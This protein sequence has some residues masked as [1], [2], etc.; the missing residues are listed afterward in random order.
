MYTLVKEIH[1][2]TTVEHC[3]YCHFFNL[4]EKNLVIASFNQLKVYRLIG[5]DTNENGSTLDTNQSTNINGNGL[6]TTSSTSISTTLN[7]SNEPTITGI[8]SGDKTNNSNINGGDN[9]N[10][11]VKLECL[12]TIPL[13]SEVCCLKSIKLIGSKRDSLLIAFADAK[14]ALVEYDPADHDLKTLSLHY[15][16]DEDIKGGRTQYPRA[17]VI[18][19]DPEGRCAAMLIYGRTIVII[20]FRK[21][22]G[23]IEE[24]E[25]TTVPG[26]GK[27]NS[28]NNIPG[29]GTSS[30]QQ[31]QVTPNKSF[32]LGKSRTSSSSLDGGDN[33]NQA[34]YPVMASYKLNLNDKQYAEEKIHNITD[35]QFL[36]GYYEPTLFIL[37]EPVRTWAGRVAVRRD[38]CSMVTLSLNVHQRVH[39]VIWSTSHLPFD[40]FAALPVPKPVGGVIIFAVNSLIYLNQSVPPYA[41]SLN[42]FADSTTAFTKTVQ[43]G[44]KL[45]LDC[46]K[47]T[48]VSNDKLV[49]SLKGGELYVVTLFSDGMRSIRA[50]HFDKSASSVISSCMTIC[51]EGYLFLGSRLGNSLLLKYTEKIVESRP[52]TAKNIPN[53]SANEDDPMMCASS[54]VPEVLGEEVDPANEPTLSQPINNNNNNS[55]TTTNINESN[56]ADFLMDFMDEEDDKSIVTSTC[57]PANQLTQESDNMDSED[58]KPS[59][60]LLD[61]SSSSSSPLED[62]IEMVKVKEEKIDSEL[63]ATNV[64]IINDSV[65]VS[66][67]NPEIKDEST[68][69]EDHPTNGI[70]DFD[71][72][73]NDQSNDSNDSPNS[74]DSHRRSPVNQ[75][76]NESTVDSL[77]N[78]NL[79]NSNLDN[80]T[81]DNSNLYGPSESQSNY[82]N[83]NDHQM[84][85]LDESEHPIN[86]FDETVNDK[87]DDIGDWAAGD[88]ALMK[89]PD[90]LEVYGPEDDDE[91]QLTTSFSFELCDSLINIGP[92]GRTCMGEPAFL[93]EEFSQNSADP[94][95]ELVTTSG[96]GKNGAL[97]VLQRTIRPQL[98]TT[99]GLPKCIDMW[100]VHSPSLGGTVND[101]YNGYQ[102]GDEKT[103]SNFHSFLILTRPDTTM[104]LKTGADINELDHSDVS[105]QTPTI[106]AGNLANGKYILQVSPMAVRLLEGT[107]QI[108]HLPLNLGS[109]IVFCS[110]VDPYAIILTQHGAMALLTLRIDP[111]TSNCRLAAS[112]VSLTPNKAKVS[113]LCIYKDVSGKFTTHSSDTSTNENQSHDNS[114]KSADG[115]E[116]GFGS[117]ESSQVPLIA[118]TIDDEDELLYGTSSIEMITN[119]PD[120][121]PSGT[122]SVT[123]EPSI[124]SQQNTE[125]LISPKVI[126]KQPEYEPTYWLFTIR[127]NGVLEI[128]RIPDATS[129]FYVKTFPMG[130]K[131]LSDMIPGDEVNRSDSGLLPVA[132]E[133]LVT[134]MGVSC[135]RPIMFARF[136]YEI[137]IYEMFPYHDAQTPG[138]LQ[139]RWRRK[140]RT[141]IV[142]EPRLI[143]T[144]VTPP[145]NTRGNVNQSSS[146]QSTTAQNSNDSPSS[147]N[148]LNFEKMHQKWFRPFND[149]SGY[150]G[151]FICGPFPHWCFMTSRGEL[152]I[153]EMNIDGPV[154]S[155]APFHNVNCPKGFLYINAKSELR[156]AVLPTHVTYDAPWPVRK[157]PLRCTIDFVNYHVD[158]KCYCVTTST[159][160]PYNRVVRVGGEEKDYDVLERDSRY[161]WP[162][163]NRFHIQ[164]FSPVSWEMI[165]GTKITLDEWEHVTCMKNVMLSSE[166]TESGL[167]GYIAAGT[168]FCYGEDVTNRGQIW[169]LDIIDVVPELGQP[170]TR[171]KIKVVYCKEQKG[172]VTAICQIR[173][174]LLSAVGQK[175]YI[176]QLK[177]SQL[178]GVAFIDTQIYIHQAVSMKNLILIA[179]VYKSI[180]L[181][182]YQ[183]DTRTL[184]L[185]SR[186][187]RAFEV[188]SCEF[189]VDNNQLCFMVADGD[190]NLL[191]Y[192]YSPESRESVG[193]TRLLRRGDYHLGSHVNCFFRIRCKYPSIVTSYFTF[194][195]SLSPQQSSSSSSHYKNTSSI[196]S[197]TSTSITTT[198][199]K[200]TEPVIDLIEAKKTTERR[201][202]TIFPTLDGTINFMLPVSEK[203][204]RRLFM[205]QNTMNAHVQHTAGVN[206]KGVHMVKFYKKCLA[207]PCKNVLDGDLLYRFLN[208]STIEKAELC[209]KISSTPDQIIDDLSEI[210]LI[211]GHF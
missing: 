42:S 156:I 123:N 24:T 4:S 89:D 188:H 76:H 8:E 32:G 104:I 160:E 40:C 132:R 191:V 39:P 106:F 55:S 88:V 83:E 206:P 195:S 136:D 147:P 86:D 59:K 110:L 202:A 204:Y 44:V 209:R 58:V 36:N 114:S 108:Q 176:W 140:E 165:P 126:P 184:A 29:P 141:L 112:L 10:N 113:T 137:F 130:C 177:E 60:E 57:E 189:I 2:S 171:S 46:S 157:V 72:P 30:S 20:P 186:D 78:N 149:V 179:D 35:F 11:K 119:L 116:N 62:N 34:K 97:C 155:F 199:N 122:N 210:D 151:V 93:P 162:T 13:Y 51:E 117:S 67:S 118:S 111:E 9:L 194:A 146:S 142:R 1:S 26:I 127:E 61:Q 96:Y 15:F 92:C 33:T 128:F 121:A 65:S 131:I 7:A 5:E 161:I 63:T 41:V 6:P 12:K 197:T 159:Q 95:V 23:S 74:P 178:V 43:K 49:L 77:F 153:H 52:K 150:S 175:I 18:R 109:P 94:Q 45:S 120:V 201:H 31:S 91:E 205:L 173:G 129:V 85:D 181:L 107:R 187:W 56:E 164:L 192:S 139:I 99:F 143:R 158:S 17:P 193:G 135:S 100:T 28:S 154:I 103:S 75:L 190:K 22:L 82:V 134:G 182:R 25:T 64:N 148:I 172:P 69:N 21:D 180:S 66:V 16:E 152:R 80:N 174:L 133:I 73:S 167:K 169:I 70:P 3:I 48:F 81:M 101:L 196:A 68:C 198:N 102:D 98:V 183:E 115:K 84:T 138:H 47:A 87:P 27:E 53:S 79:D 145:V 163:M 207:N 144:T 125:Q 90:E 211:T 38:T 168:N 185:A 71:D 37:H 170:L 50:F 14:L 54:P 203:I 105:S 166:G 208:L 200:N 124:S 19:V